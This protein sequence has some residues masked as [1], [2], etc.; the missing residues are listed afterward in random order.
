MFLHFNY[1]IVQWFLVILLCN[2]GLIQNITTAVTVIVEPRNVLQAAK[3]EVFVNCTTSPVEDAQIIWNKGEENIPSYSEGTKDEVYV[4][5]NNTLYLKSLKKKE[6]GTYTCNAFLTLEKLFQTVVIEVAFLQKLN[7]ID[8]VKVLQ[9]YVAEIVCEEPVGKPQPKVKW[10]YNGATISPDNPNIDS[11]SWT[12]RIKKTMLS[13][14]G[15]YTCVAFNSVAERTAEAKLTVVVVGD[16]EVSPIS[17]SIKEGESATFKCESKSDPPLNVKWKRDIETCS[18]TGSSD[19]VCKV[20]KEDVIPSDRVIIS[21]GTLSIK[22]AS[23]KDEGIYLCETELST[24]IS[25]AKVQLNVFELM[26]VDKS[27]HN[28]IQTCDRLRQNNTKITCHFKGDG[29]YSIQW[30]RLSPNT[31]FN[32]NMK[33]VNDSIYISDLKFEDMGHFK[34]EAVGEYNNATAYV[35]FIVYEHPQFVISPKNITA[36]IGEPAWV[37]CQGKGFP[38]PRVYILRG[39]KDGGNLNNSYFVQLPNDTFYIKSLKKEYSGEYFCWLIEQYGSISDTF[40]ITVLEKEVSTGKGSPMGRTVGIAVGCAGV[41]ILLVIGLMIYCRAR[42]ARLFKKGKLVE[43][44]GEPLAEDRLLGASDI[45]LISIEKLIFNYENLQEIMVLGYGKFG[46]VFKAHAK[47][48]CEDGTDTLVAVKV[49]EET[50]VNNVLS[51]FNKETEDLMQFQNN[52][53]VR[54][55]G[56]VRE[57]P[58]CIITEYSELGDLKE[59]LQTNKSISSSARLHMCTCIAKGMS[60]LAT[61]NYVHRDLAAR[62]CILFSQNEVKVSFLSLCNTTYKDDYYLLNN[63]LAPVRWL[64]PES[65]REDIYNEK[66]DV[67]S[68]SVTMW[69]IFSS[70][71]QPFYGVSNEEVVNRIGKDLQFTIPSNCPKTLY[72]IMTR[73]WLVNAFDRPTFDELLSLMAEISH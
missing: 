57:S 58:F 67:W 59:Y 21:S 14:A 64:A 48:I 69:E 68:F 73:C 43:V 45:P 22:N 33:V 54:L 63:L 20:S 31:I 46:K 19:S 34:C 4:L 30:T 47:G 3:T 25:S 50:P 52:Y 5:P 49:F 18:T 23:V 71:V 11:S 35:N 13:D 24:Q 8:P 60:Y 66:T 41:Y 62:N 15:N 70:E 37:H 9:G 39:K 6:A 42:R 29:K 7:P 10:L 56:L 72:K 36:Y 32:S 44:D 28:E 16:V 12:L 53:V 40:S 26:K 61:L 2:N 65:I 27:L 1:K 17:N 38:K 55:L 51:A